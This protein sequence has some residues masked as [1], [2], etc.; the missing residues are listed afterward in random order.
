MFLLD[1]TKLKHLN[2]RSFAN[3]LHLKIV[4]L[5][6]NQIQRA[7]NKRDD[8]MSQDE[9]F[10]P[11]L[12][13]IDLSRNQFTANFE[14]SFEESSKLIQLNLSHNKLTTVDACLFSKL[15]HLKNLVVEYNKLDKKI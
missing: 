15:C 13:D 10:F 2:L 9:D 14:G 12:E 1:S 3:L 6:C 4:K 7:E 11:I 5:S 8:R